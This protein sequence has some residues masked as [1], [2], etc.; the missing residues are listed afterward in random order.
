MILLV[1][2][3]ANAAGIEF[4]RGEAAETG[5]GPA[6]A[7]GS[8]SGEATSTAS[9]E[10]AAST[11]IPTVVAAVAGGLINAVMSSTPTEGSG[12]AA[13]SGP[14]HL[15]P[16]AHAAIQAAVSFFLVA[17]GVRLLLY[18]I[19]AWYLPRFRAFHLFEGVIIL[20]NMVWYFPLLAI[21]RPSVIIALPCTAIVTELVG[22]YIFAKLLSWDRNTQYLH[23]GDVR[24]PALN[25]GYIH[26]RCTAFMVVVLGKPAILSHNPAPLPVR[27]N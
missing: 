5:A 6:P 21:T 20:I 12:A 27:G 24:I 19:Y 4:E 14:M 25:V 11:V 10:G 3:A 16:S 18:L 9:A 17:K 2:Y 8:G 13:G 15:A 23:E 7:T 1:G 22:R 26:E